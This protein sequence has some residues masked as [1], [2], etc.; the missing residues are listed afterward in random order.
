M[1]NCKVEKKILLP[2]E[3][4]IEIAMSHAR[5]TCNTNATPFVELTNGI[6]KITLWSYPDPFRAG[7]MKSDAVVWID[8]VAGNRKDMAVAMGGTGILQADR[9][10]N[11]GKTDEQRKKNMRMVGMALNTLKHRA[12]RG[13]TLS[14]TPE[15]DMVPPQIVRETARKHVRMRQRSY[16][17]SR[18][19]PVF[20]VD[21][22]YIV[23]FWKKPESIGEKG[24]TYDCR[25]GIDAYNGQVINMEIT[26]GN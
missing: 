24:P 5:D 3:E 20:L 12:I 6:Y 8:A 17:A 1:N 16:D 21:D 4:V 26:P 18:E 14:D 13:Q 7:P 9:Y 15:K 19:P 2:V 23:V 11:P 25:V 22:I 10:S